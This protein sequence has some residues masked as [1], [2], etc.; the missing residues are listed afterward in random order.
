MTATKAVP[1]RMGWDYFVEMD[2]P[3]DPSVPLDRQPSLPKFL[4]Q[5]KSSAKAR[6]SVKVKLSAI[7]R[8]VDADLPAF[9]IF[10]VIDERSEI[11]ETLLLHIGEKQIE[12]ILT[13]AR[14]FEARARVDL[15]NVKI[16]LPLIGSEAI[17]IN[18]KN[19]PEYLSIIVKDQN[20][21]S[22]KR[23]FRARCGYGLNSI[24]AHVV[25]GR[26]ID[27]EK[28]VDLMIG[29]IPSLRVE[30][31]EVR[32]SRFGIVVDK[33][34][35]RIEGATMMVNDHGGG[36]DGVIIASSRTGGTRASLN[37][38]IRAPAMRGMGRRR[39]KIRIYNAYIE[40]ICDFEV[41]KCTFRFHIE[42]EY[43][44][45]INALVD[46]IRFGQTIVQ[47]DCT[48]EVEVNNRS[49]MIS[50]A[51]SLDGV[52]SYWPTILKFAELIVSAA[53]RSG[54]RKAIETSLSELTN[55]VDDNESS[56]VIL[57][58]AGIE[59]TSDFEEPA[60]PSFPDHS[61][62]IL[63][64]TMKFKGLI[65]SAIVNADAEIKLSDD[66]LHATFVCAVPTIVEELLTEKDRFDSAALNER[67][68]HLGKE[69]K[70][71]SKCVVTM[72]LQE[73][74]DQLGVAEV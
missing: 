25:F 58:K 69:V 28:V 16:S 73:I 39:T 59:F 56:F 15:H 34:V 65:Y 13:S 72:E 61:I 51:L 1:D 54:H 71:D 74:E 32:K 30:R 66:R 46:G 24:S 2:P 60:P 36:Q 42:P 50:R 26:D 37:V 40:M 57:T 64:I 9:L 68:Q 12:H 23:E 22:W 49:L 53:R 45:E 3:V 33:D 4:V 70:S 38:K 62:V 7:K 14:K 43:I 5:V 48:V 17:A 8:L 21:I 27:E 11:I 20:Y 47:P 18:N 67:A 63:P 6:K 29:A 10:I 55:A 35:D 41:E 19:I 44:C 31:M 52:R